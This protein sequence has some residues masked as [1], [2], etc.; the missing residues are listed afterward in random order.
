MSLD[1]CKNILRD[2]NQTVLQLLA[3]TDQASEKVK[4][5]ST[6]SFKDLDARG[7]EQMS[8]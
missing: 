3:G 4:D 2:T 1:N 8:Q 6:V 5:F 7:S